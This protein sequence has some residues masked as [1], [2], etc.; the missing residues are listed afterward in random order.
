V[1]FDD[2]ALRTER[3]ILRRRRDEHHGART[4][5]NSDTWVAEFLNRRGR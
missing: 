4:A 1:S 5:I 3:L 2:E